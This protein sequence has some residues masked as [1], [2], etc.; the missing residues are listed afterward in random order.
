MKSLFAGPPSLGCT[1]RLKKREGQ[2]QLVAG[3]VHKGEKRRAAEERC[4]CGM[5]AKEQ[6]KKSVKTAKK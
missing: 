3:H 6:R 1:L 4:L 2:G 5:R